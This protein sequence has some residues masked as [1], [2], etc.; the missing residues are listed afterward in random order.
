MGG[1]SMRFDGY[2]S[3]KIEEVLNPRHQPAEGHI[4]SNAALEQETGIGSL[5]AEFSLGYGTVFGLFSLALPSDW[6]YV[7]L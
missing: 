5:Y 2:V 3:L 4:S 6:V 7:N 1:S